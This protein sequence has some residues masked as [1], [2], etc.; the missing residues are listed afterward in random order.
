MHTPQPNY[1]FLTWIPRRSDEVQEAYNKNLA[2]HFLHLQALRARRFLNAGLPAGAHPRP[3][4]PNLFP[5]DGG[6][7]DITNVLPTSLTGKQV[8]E[9]KGGKDYNKIHTI[10]KGAF[11]IVYKVTK[12]S[13]GS[14][15]AAKEIEK[16]RFIKNG[17]LDLKM[18]SE[19]RIMSSI[20][21]QNIV[22]YIE[23][24]DWHDYVFI[25]MEYVPEGDLG[26]QVAKQGR[27]AEADVKTI[28]CQ[29]LDALKYLHGKGITHRD[30]KP[31]NVLIAQTDPFQ[32][33]LTDFGLSKM[34][35]NEETFMRT[36]CGTLLYCAPEVYH[37]YA[38]Y[39][40]NGQRT[41][42][43]GQ[44]RRQLQRYGQAVDIWSLGGVLFY[45]LAAAPPYPVS[46]KEVTH[47]SFLQRI[48]QEPLD[49]RPL[50]KADCSEN[51]WHFI[52]DMLHTRPEYRATIEQLEQHRWMTG[53]VVESSQ[54]DV[55]EQSSQ[56]SQLNIDGSEEEENEL[57]D[58]VEVDE[59]ISQVT[60]IQ[61]RE[62]PSSFDT[63]DD[64]DEVME[65]FDFELRTGPKN[66]LFGE[67][68]ASDVGSSG[69]IPADQLNLPV[70][71]EACADFDASGY[72][73]DF[74]YSQS[75][76]LNTMSLPN[77]ENLISAMGP[78][79]SHLPPTPTRT[80]PPDTERRAA[81]SSSLMG[82]ES[83]VGNLNMQSP[84]SAASPLPETSPADSARGPSLRRPREVDS[85]EDEDG[86]KPK[87]LPAKKRRL[88]ER[89]I[90]LDMPV[91]TF[92]AQ[93]DKSTH[94]NNYPRMNTDEWSR[95]NQLAKSK[96][97]EFRPGYKI[98]ES[99]MQSFRSSRSRSSSREPR[100]YSEPTVDEGRRMMVKRDERLLEDQANG[101]PTLHQ[102]DTIPDTAN[103]S[104][105]D[106]SGLVPGDG[107]QVVGSDFTR[108]E[109]VLAKM[110]STA[111]SFLPTINI[112]ITGCIT[113]WGRGKHVTIRYPHK[114]EVR[115][116]KLAFKI[117]AFKPG[118]YDR[119][120][121][122]A[123]LDI[124]KDNDMSFYIS[125]KAQSGIW[126][127]GSHLSSYNS[128]DPGMASRYWAELRNG[129]VIVVWKSDA[130]A[131]ESTVFR[132]DCYWGKSMAV[133]QPGEDFKTITNLTFLADLEAACTRQERAALANIA[134]RASEDQRLIEASREAETAR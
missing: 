126:V 6:T 64:M 22:Q 53:E 50:Q 44:G 86:W 5:A 36:F 118:F 134:A 70:A 2:Q 71:S 110:C 69:A 105:G 25:I 87:D 27:L 7:P 75:P 42:R 49:V 1:V 8:R 56:L 39:D 19:M 95:F 10:G 21:H 20:Q 131:A 26:T 85:D 83:M 63:D 109:K 108:P 24:I 84:A 67:V 13:D 74:E 119:Q 78:P 89:H 77:K 61:R 43:R 35:D 59:D 113:S 46:S 76:Q 101:P 82:T 124:E 130:A 122:I 100:A 128:E 116:P 23:H 51:G 30:I 72:L 106:A 127:N 29:L 80:S 133:R 54:E 103:G 57:A 11:A 112:N 38:D 34:V 16:R 97:E 92:W 31:D 33:K 65:D 79:P 9:W 32:T 111:D 94:H 88:S 73:Q 125:S 107:L 48:M 120:N 93:H 123:K 40:A 99:S 81:R 37:E 121:R 102:E 62:I 132:F 14:P 47:D 45:C 3:Q 17:V 15:F 60:E 96:G 114:T 129:D 91:S 66:R 18:E 104:D 98:F 58:S 12:K 117:M 68:N 4:P 115:I 52:R 90:V 41:L 55:E 28:A